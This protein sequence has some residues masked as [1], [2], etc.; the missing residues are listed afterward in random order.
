MR[1][2]ASDENCQKSA[3][4]VLKVGVSQVSAR[5]ERAFRWVRRRSRRSVR[6][7]LSEMKRN[8]VAWHDTEALACKFLGRVHYSNEK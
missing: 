1:N 7:L 5:I 6:K 8:A 4:N 3:E 2:G